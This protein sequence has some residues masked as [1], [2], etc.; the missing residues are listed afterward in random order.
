[1]GRKSYKPLDIVVVKWDD[2]GERRTMIV[3]REVGGSYFGI[4]LDD[5]VVTYM[6]RGSQQT[7]QCKRGDCESFDVSQV[8]RKVGE[9]SI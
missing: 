1:M 7:S 2:I 4:E 9:A 5:D 8:V 6:Y 3:K